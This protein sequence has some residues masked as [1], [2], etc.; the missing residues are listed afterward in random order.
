VRRKI[1]EANSSNYDATP[2]TAVGSSDDD[3]NA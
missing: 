1:I 2:D 3:D